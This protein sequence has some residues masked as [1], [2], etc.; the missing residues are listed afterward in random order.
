MVDRISRCGAVISMAVPPVPCCTEDPFGWRDDLVTV[1][2]NVQ[3]SQEEY[4]RKEFGDYLLRR[5]HDPSK[6]Q[7]APCDLH[8]G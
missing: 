5:T 6:R 7:R 3:M 2:P 4:V 1:P 8:S